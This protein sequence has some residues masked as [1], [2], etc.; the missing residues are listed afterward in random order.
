MLNKDEFEIKICDKKIE[1]ISKLDGFVMIDFNLFKKELDNKIK[2]KFFKEN[3][4]KKGEKFLEIEIDENDEFSKLKTI[5]LLLNSDLINLGKIKEVICSI[6]LIKEEIDLDEKIVTHLLNIFKNYEIFVDEI[7][8]VFPE[9]D[10]ILSSINDL[11][12]K[13]DFVLILFEEKI[14]DL[15]KKYLKDFG[16]VI[17]SLDFFVL[18]RENKKLI[19]SSVEKIDEFMDNILKEVYLQWKFLA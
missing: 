10:E 18:K 16:Y 19:V 15:I 1:L 7:N 6:I 14:K 17:K 5:N 11:L 3:F 2:I 4:I 13:S 8:L 9:E 12:I